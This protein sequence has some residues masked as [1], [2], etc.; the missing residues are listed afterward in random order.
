V[1][2]GQ[3]DSPWVTRA[4]VC[5]CARVRV[6]LHGLVLVCVCVCVCVCACVCVCVCACVC[7]RACV[8]LCQRTDRFCK[9][10]I[11]GQRVQARGEEGD[12]GRPHAQLA[13][14]RLAGVATHLCRSPHP[15]IHVH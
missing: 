3:D 8:C 2:Q 13:R 5:L 12:A 4:C 1:C 14:G 15:H 11:E 7:V 10:A 9:A 6:C